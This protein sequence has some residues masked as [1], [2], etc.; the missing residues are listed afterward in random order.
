MAGGAYFLHRLA[1]FRWRHAAVAI[2]LLMIVA[3]LSLAFS[4]ARGWIPR[5]APVT[6][7]E[8]WQAILRL[9]AVKP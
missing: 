3:N 4:F 6:H 1:A 8:M 2:A 5:D 7:L 9:G